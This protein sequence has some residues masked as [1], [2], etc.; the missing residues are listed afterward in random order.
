MYGREVRRKTIQV[1]SALNLKISQT[2]GRRPST[3][4]TVETAGDPNVKFK[5][6]RALGRKSPSQLDE[7]ST[8]QFSLVN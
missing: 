7:H 2:A 5:V 4:R 3:K 8:V 6:E 1:A